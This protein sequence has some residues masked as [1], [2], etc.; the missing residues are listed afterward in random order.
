MIF[1]GDLNDVS[2]D[3][4]NKNELHLCL[5]WNKSKSQVI[6]KLMKE[7]F[8]RVG[9]EGLSNNTVLM[10]KHV[11]QHTSWYDTQIYKKVIMVSRASVIYEEL[12]SNIW[13][14]IPWDLKFVKKT[15][16]P[17]PL[18]SLESFKFHKSRSPRP[19]K[20]PS[21]STR[22]NCENMCSWLERPKTILKI[23][24]KIIFL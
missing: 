23:R 12:G 9:G 19:V 21:N 17:N 15:S 5:L 13:P 18:K 20:N 3:Q 4:S 24:K 2:L 10:I 8:V 22:Y 1:W 16:M 6:M 7:K 11:T 14:E